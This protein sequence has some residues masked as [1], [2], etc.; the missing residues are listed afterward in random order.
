MGTQ[1]IFSADDWGLSPGINDGIVELA[2]RG[3]LRLVSFVAN[4]T[5]LEH[6]LEKIRS[7]SKIQTSLHLNFTYGKP[8][9]PPRLIP[10]LVDSNGFFFPH[11]QLLTRTALGLVVTEHLVLELQAHLGRLRFLGLQIDSLDGHHHIHLWP[12]IF[13]RI[14]SE[15]L[16]QRVTSLR[17]MADPSHRLSYWQSQLFLRFPRDEI[18]QLKPCRYLTNNDQRCQSRLAK[19]IQA[20]DEPLLV[21]PA[22]YNDFAKVKMSDSLQ[23][24]RVS[25]FR[26]ILD[27]FDGNERVL[28]K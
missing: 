7:F 26:F 28:G 2:E 17:W 19:K 11:R 9:T 21:H 20:S 8:L 16:T 12:F 22:L 10:S 25:Q 6:R 4:A 3:L 1:A 18:F 23:E 5:F 14:E 27:Y 13:K 15:L 24:D